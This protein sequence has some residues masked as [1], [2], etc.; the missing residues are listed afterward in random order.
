MRPP[1]RVAG[2]TLVEIL[3]VLCVIAV[4]AGILVPTLSYAR[5]RSRMLRCAANLN[6]ISVATKLYY[7]DHHAPPLGSLPEALGDYVDSRE[8]FVCP[9]DRGG[10]DSYSEFYAA[11]SDPTGTQFLVGCPRHGSHNR[12]TVGF[13]QGQCDDVV[14]AP[15]SS[16]DGP[17]E[18]GDVITGGELTFADGSRVTVAPGGQVGLLMSFNDDGVCHSVIFVPKESFTSLHCEV[19]PG[20]RFEVVTPASIAGVEGTKFDVITSREYDVAGNVLY[21]TDVVVYEGKVKVTNRVGGGQRVL[22]PGLVGKSKTRG[23]WAPDDPGHGNG[24]GKGQGD[25]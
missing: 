12:G 15:V 9:E 11:R 23:R 20:S 24:Q 18:P 13:G 19:T 14:M 6:Q 17:V 4:L 22:P 25:D 5:G 7:E 10:T 8:V 3:V 1:N 16:A 2:I 21:V